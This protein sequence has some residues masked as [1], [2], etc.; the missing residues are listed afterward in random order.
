MGKLYRG[1]EKWTTCPS[2]PADHWQA[3]SLQSKSSALSTRPHGQPSV[4]M[5]VCGGC[6][7]SV[8]N[9]LMFRYVDCNPPGDWAAIKLQ[10]YCGTVVWSHPSFTV[11]RNLTIKQKAIS[12]VN[13]Y[14]CQ[15]FGSSWSSMLEKKKSGYLEFK[16]VKSAKEIQMSY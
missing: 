10:L 11:G 15:R 7:C 3:K 12:R 9:F 16:N 2:H 8:T 5:M 1:T 14:W 6:W 13:W 4:I